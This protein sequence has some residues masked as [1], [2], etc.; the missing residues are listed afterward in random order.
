MKRSKKCLLP[1]SMGVRWCSD[2]SLERCQRL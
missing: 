1:M 2:W